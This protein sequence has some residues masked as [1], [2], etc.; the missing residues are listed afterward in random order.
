VRWHGSAFC[1]VLVV[2]CIIANLSPAWSQD[3]VEARGWVRN[4]FGRIILDWPAPVGYRAAIEGRRLVVRFDRAFTTNFGELLPTLSSY[5]SGAT[6]SANGRVADFALKGRFFLK[7]YAKGKSIILDL[8]RATS[9][10]QQA[11]AT[12]Q[13]REA[14]GHDALNIRVGRNK[15]FT[16]IVFDWEQ[17]IDYTTFTTGDRVTVNFGRNAEIDIARLRPSLPAG[18]TN[19]TAVNRAGQLVF[20]LDKGPTRDVQD[21][22]VG[23]KIVLD[24]FEAKIA[25]KLGP[26]KPK[27]LKIWKAEHRPRM[28]RV[29]IAKVGTLLERPIRPV[30][31]PVPPMSLAPRAEA[32]AERPKLPQR[33]AEA[34]SS[35][36]LLEQAAAD[37]EKTAANEQ[38]ETALTSEAVKLMLGVAK[39]VPKVT[40]ATQEIA[41]KEEV[42]SPAPI[43]VRLVFDWSEPVGAAVFRREKF[44]WVVFDRHQLLD[45]TRLRETS[46]ALIEKIEQL[47]FAGGTVL[48]MKAKPGINPKVSQSG[49]KWEL[50]FGRWPIEPD[51][52]IPLEINANDAGAAQLLFKNAESFKIINVPDPEI[53]DMIRVAALPEAGK[54]IWAK[55]RYPEF[56]VLASSQGVALVPLSDEVEFRNERGKG[57]LVSSAG[58]LFVSAVSP[59]TMS[60]RDPL[61]GERL[62][63][64]KAWMKGEGDDF[65]EARQAALRAIVEVPEQ[66]R[67]KARLE[68][69]QFYFSHGLGAETLGILRVIAK[70][71][72]SAMGRTE[73]IALRGAARLLANHVDKAK[74]DLSNRRLDRFREAFLWRGLL[75]AKLGNWKKASENFRKG[76]SVLRTYPN[77][78]RTIIGIERVEA[79]LRVFDVNSATVWLD[80]LRQNEENM[81]RDQRARLWYNQGLLARANQDLDGARKFWDMAIKSGDTFNG[82]RSKLALVDLGVKQETMAP[83]QAIE[84][85]ERLRYQWRGDELELNVLEK[86]G[87][88][89]LDKGDF[90]KGL[91]RLRVAVSYFPKS[92]QTDHIAKRMAKTFKQLYL[93][94]EAEKLQPLS[95]LALYDEYRE[96]TPAGSEGDEMIGRLADR[97]V[98]VDLLDRAA[99]LLNH[100]IRFR[101]KGE[102]QSEA[103]TKLALVHLLNRKPKAALKVLR[104]TFRP[105]L[106][107]QT[108][109]DRRRIRAK[110]M[111]ELGKNKEAIG[112]LAGDVSVAADQ[113]RAD[114]YWRAQDY[115]EAAKVLQRL[116]GEP[117]RQGKY[118]MSRAQQ[119]LNW[120]V[121]MR[122]DKDEAGLKLA[123]ELYGPAMKNSPLGDAFRYIAIPKTTVTGD[124]EGISKRITEIDQFE[125]FLNNYRQRLLKPVANKKG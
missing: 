54:G 47:P 33:K 23:N 116:A 57:L 31:Q 114:I 115:R 58:G 82:V 84:R 81:R 67:E 119:V 118:G 25:P 13:T 55:R 86:L 16:R 44:I 123:R 5:L 18:L 4:S 12:A 45:L 120:A 73:F 75:D 110:A 72:A 105:G 40:K 96:L 91:A 108:Q 48:R 50:K 78:L 102:K 93:K 29:V 19:P 68:F 46:K 10:P 26:E 7:T 34:L 41:P 107:Q 69:A 111:F 85:L 8:R 32:L 61:I 9:A 27:K 112:L 38:L 53:G 66:N 60:R 17:R 124:L 80:N 97:L 65:I 37:R 52:P 36:T 117:L 51:L 122:L 98:S 30:E 92:E 28:E 63:K 94:G 77:P 59:E 39:L 121:A 62:F 15:G 103:G 43:P 125:A 3:S 74:E 76:D 83:P 11:A 64:P 24:I 20:S 49:F 22:R 2:L 14:S 104:T 89:Y 1:A 99:D 88:H 70:A 113:L 56:Q 71:N 87:N 106:P 101:L 100:Q 21:L 109:D 79:A 90:R 95:A 6:I 35:P 42:K